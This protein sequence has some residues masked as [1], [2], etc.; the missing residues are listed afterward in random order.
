MGMGVR[1]ALLIATTVAVAVATDGQE[2]SCAVVPS[3]GR[4]SG[5]RATAS[6]TQ[7]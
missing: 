3:D 4:L 2:L 7:S 6:A 1:L 5:A